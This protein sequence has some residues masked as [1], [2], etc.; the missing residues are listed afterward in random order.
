MVENKIQE[1][2]FIIP[3]SRSKEQFEKAIPA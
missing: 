2:E 1:K 3:I